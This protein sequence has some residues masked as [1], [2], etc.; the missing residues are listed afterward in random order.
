MKNFSV[1]LILSSL[2]LLSSCTWVKLTTE[3]E[4]VSVLTEAGVAG[5]MRTGTTTVEVLDKTIINR[6]PAKVAREL[7]TLARNRAAGRGNAIVASTEVVDGEQTFVI[8]QCQ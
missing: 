6:N 2:C 1:P 7:R 3:G 5:C 8:Y 4:S